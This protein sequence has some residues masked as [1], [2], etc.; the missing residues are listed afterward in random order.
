M[1]KRS[2][3]KEIKNIFQL[4]L[5]KINF[6]HGTKIGK[7]KSKRKSSQLQAKPSHG[8]KI[9]KKEIAIQHLRGRKE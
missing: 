8:A 9:G 1:H 5:S 7:W 6:A 2:R 4:E 3:I